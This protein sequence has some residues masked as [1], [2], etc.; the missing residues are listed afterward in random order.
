MAVFKLRFLFGLIL[1]LTQLSAFAFQKQAE[2]PWWEPFLQEYAQASQDG[3]RFAWSETSGGIDLEGTIEFVFLGKSATLDSGSKDLILRLY[4]RTLERFWS[5]PFEASAERS[6]FSVCGQNFSG[7]R[8][9]GLALHIVSEKVPVAPGAN[10]VYFYY[11]DQVPQAMSLQNFL[12]ATFP[13]IAGSEE[14]FQ[15]DP[16]WERKGTGQLPAFT[17][18]LPLPMDAGVRPSDAFGPRD[19]SAASWSLFVGH[20]FGHVLGLA[21]GWHVKGDQLVATD[22]ELMSYLVW[23]LNPDPRTTHGY[24]AEIISRALGCDVG[25]QKNG[26][27]Y[28]VGPGK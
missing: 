14:A 25:W 3:L 19:P 12:H 15:T 28:W 11:H 20:E 27:T 10:R 5:M 18:F 24:F 17:Q 23:E 26:S 4:R 1:L 9:D 13:T 2:T 21:D 6:D 22:T 7:F 8:Y 16:F